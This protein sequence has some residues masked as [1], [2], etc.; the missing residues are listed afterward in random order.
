MRSYGTTLMSKSFESRL[1][2][3]PPVPEVDYQ[4]HPS[5]VQYM[6]GKRQSASFSQAYAVHRS[7]PDSVDWYQGSSA[8]AANRLGI[9][10]PGEKR[11]RLSMTPSMIQ[12]A[13]EALPTGL[14]IEMKDLGVPS[15]KDSLKD[16]IIDSGPPDGGTLAWAH[17]VA[18]HLVTMNAQ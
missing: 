6:Y 1:K 5:H 11:W 14:A 15:A 7:K 12:Q 8:K 13:T 4:A 9:A 17:A 2:P 10:E 18:G 3:L 16:D